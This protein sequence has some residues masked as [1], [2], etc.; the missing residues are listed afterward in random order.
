MAFLGGGG[1]GGERKK[2][3]ARSSGSDGLKIVE[4]ND[5]VNR[6]SWRV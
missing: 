2:P 1:D 6:N 4:R 3:T 5:R